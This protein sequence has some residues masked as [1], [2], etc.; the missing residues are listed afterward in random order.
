ML[1][2]MQGTASFFASRVGILV[3][4]WV[5]SFSLFFFEKGSL[6]SQSTKRKDALF[7]PWPLGIRGML[8][9]LGEAFNVKVSM[10]KDLQMKKRRLALLTD[11]YHR[12]QSRRE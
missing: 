3:A 12:M 8:V 6:L 2:E 10:C 11:A 7:S 5:A 1:R 4:Q 9:F